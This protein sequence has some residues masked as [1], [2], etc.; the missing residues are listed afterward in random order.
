MDLDVHGGLTFS[1]QELRVEDTKE[2]PDYYW[3]G[4][5]CAHG[6]DLSPGMI[7]LGLSGDQQYRNIEYAE[8]ETRSLAKQFAGLF[9]VTVWLNRR[10]QPSEIFS[11]P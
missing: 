6:G 9:T 5:D 2:F 11:A 4:F 10:R 1:A 8:K 7:S 3:H